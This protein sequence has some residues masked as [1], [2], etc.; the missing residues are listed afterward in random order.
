M[1]AAAVEVRTNLEPTVPLDSAPA[2]SIINW[3]VGTVLLALTGLLTFLAKKVFDGVLK[4]IEEL[5]KKQEA[6]IKDVVTEMK[7]IASM[8]QGQVTQMAL[9]NQKIGQL[10]EEL[11]RQSRELEMARKRHHHLVNVLGP[12][13]G[14]RIAKDNPDNE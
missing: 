10:E 2:A 13:W 11:R 3:V 9:V 6:A 8:V 14:K 12:E 4:N 1:A 7:G 5:G